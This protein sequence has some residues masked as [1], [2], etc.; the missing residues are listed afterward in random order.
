MA[1]TAEI[2]TKEMITEAL[3]A[4]KTLVGESLYK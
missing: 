1:T 4:M 3:T 2:E